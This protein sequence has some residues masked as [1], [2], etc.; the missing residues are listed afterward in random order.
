MSG[1]SELDHVP[2]PYCAMLSLL[3]AGYWKLLSPLVHRAGR[4]AT[5][6]STLTLMF[7]VAP[8]YLPGG[9]LT[10]NVIV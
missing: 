7:T 10:F 4:R 1:T 5:L 3:A 2:C 9:P 6:V 8:G